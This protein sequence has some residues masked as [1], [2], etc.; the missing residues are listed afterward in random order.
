MS[1]LAQ[2]RWQRSG[3]VQKTCSLF[4]HLRPGYCESQVEATP[5]FVDTGPPSS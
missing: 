2:M 3:E 1:R 4:A 5:S